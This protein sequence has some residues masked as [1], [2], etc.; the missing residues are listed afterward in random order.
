[1][2]FF[3]GAVELD[4]WIAAARPPTY[5]IEW[6]ICDAKTKQKNKSAKNQKFKLILISMKN[7]PEL[8]KNRGDIQGKA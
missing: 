7:H 3:F 2:L 4:R 8:K 6:K 1:M 5:L